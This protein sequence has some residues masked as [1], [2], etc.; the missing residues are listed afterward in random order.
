MRLIGFAARLAAATLLLSLAACGNGP[1]WI[2][3]GTA[4][5]VTLRWYADTTPTGDANTVADRYCET[6]GKSADIGVLQ[7]DGSAAVG[8]Y[9]C[10]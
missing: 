7:R 1:P 5:S 8:Q 4:R 9:R 6:M 10:G 2:L 3:H